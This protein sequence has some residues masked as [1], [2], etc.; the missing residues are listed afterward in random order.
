MIGPGLP[1]AGV[2]IQPSDLKRAHALFLELA[3]LPRPAQRA[4][5]SALGPGEEELVAYVDEMLQMDAG[6]LGSMDAVAGLRPD[7]ILQDAVRDLPLQI[8]GLDILR[9]LGRGGMGVVY[10]AQQRVPARRVALKTLPPLRETPEMVALL[11]A[12]LE[13]L[14]RV[15]HPGVPAVYQLLEHEGLPVLAMELVRGRPLS[16]A[17]VGAS[18][19]ARLE[20]WIGA[21]EALAAA[22]AQGVVHR[23]VKPLNVLVTEAGQV[24][25]LDFGIAALEGEVAA[26]AGTPAYGAPEQLRGER[27]TPA[28]DVYGLGALGWFLWTGAPPPR[29]G[30]DGVLRPQGMGPELFAVLRLALNPDPARRYPDAG[31]LLRDLRAG[32]E[33]RVVSPLSGRPEAHLRA[34][35]RRNR[36]LVGILGVAAAIALL[37]VGARAWQRHAADVA[38]EARAEQELQCLLALAEALD[39]EDPALDEAF[40]AL[41]RAPEMADTRALHEAW[42]W[43][44]AQRPSL[45]AAGM[46]WATAPGDAVR[47]LALIRLAERLCE[48][49]RFDALERILGELPADALPEQRLA[50]A[51]QRRDLD[52]AEALLDPSLRPALELL[53]QARPVPEGAPVRLSEAGYAWVT[54]ED[55]LHVLGVRGAERRWSY[56]DRKLRALRRAPDGSLWFVAEHGDAATLYVVRPEDEAPREVAQGG[57]ELRTTDLDDIDQDGVL[58]RYQLSGGEAP[59]LLVAEPAEGPLRAVPGLDLSAWDARL[60]G[61][62][63]VGDA[64]AFVLRSPEV[65]GVLMVRG[66]PE[67]A[68]PG[69][70]IRTAY[71]FTRADRERLL[72][73]GMAPGAR[74]A[75]DEPLSALPRALVAL[76][77]RDP[78]ALHALGVVGPEVRGFEVLALGAGGPSFLAFLGG[79]GSWIVAPGGARLPLPG[80]RV[81]SAGQLD[82]DPDPELLVKTEEGS[83][84]LGVEGAPPLPSLQGEPLPAPAAPPPEV[85]GVA[86]RTWSRLEDLVALGL[87]QETAGLFERLGANAGPVGT[88]ALRRA[89]E[90]HPE[91]DDRA[92]VARQLTTR[93]LEPGLRQAAMPALTTAHDR[94]A[95][96]RLVGRAP[97]ERHV[98]VDLAPPLR[99]PA[100]DGALSLGEE[101][102]VELRLQGQAR[103]GLELPVRWDGEGVAVE[104]DLD[105][106]ELDWATRVVL[107]LEGEGWSA[108][109]NTGRWGLADWDEDFNTSVCRIGEVDDVQRRRLLAGE[110]VRLRLSWLEGSGGLRCQLDEHS[111]IVPTDA[112]PPPGPLTVRLSVES[113]RG[114]A[115]RLRVRSLTLE[116]AS[117]YDDGARDP[118]L[119]MVLGDPEAARRASEASDPA[120][121]MEARR[122]LGLPAPEASEQTWARLLRQDPERWLPAAA[123]ALGPRWVEALYAAWLT[124]LSTDDPWADAML[125]SP[126][127]PPLPLDTAPGRAL[128]I[129][130]CEALLRARRLG[131]AERELAPLRAL[132]LDEA[133]RLTALLRV[134]QGEVDAARA[135]AERW[136]ARSERPAYDLQRALNDPRLRPLVLSTRPA[137]LE[138]E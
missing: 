126:L 65:S 83:W 128:A 80:V 105:I 135:A 72:I 117:P 47:Q 44:D 49:G 11:R 134:A 26:A 118:G 69:E 76:D 56:P 46:S 101:G 73:L 115:A 123:R 54:A 111:V 104:L 114:D 13:A 63:R 96:A 3:D 97:P 2:T 25:V 131:D 4:A 88:A 74:G 27:V 94:E 89:L 112:A 19:A 68:E 109:I 79:E 5:L 43:R 95:L 35:V 6:T 24:K 31:A 59:G 129:E 124:P 78:S 103:V 20:M 138:L 52:A 22:H 15:E 53:R 34:F 7:A 58:E 64:A 51:M 86:R 60:L 10:E 136:L 110:R 42:T 8:A 77:P 17:A 81:Q 116:G 113:R 108:R 85:T 70:F 99:L 87:V 125:R 12:E 55:T 33:G 18:D 36:L 29:T 28:T 67:R 127:L 75:P 66:L 119:A 92:R 98:L 39:A 71:F 132:D 37:G 45:E 106:L 93:P 133:W 38:R 130:R 62:R 90:L 40:E 107:E 1:V 16:E 121:A 82:G 91:A 57:A 32:A 9:E 48:Q 120:L 41:A 14:A 137:P 122:V 100:P 102:L 61:L 30:S 21:T 84:V 23:D 50:L